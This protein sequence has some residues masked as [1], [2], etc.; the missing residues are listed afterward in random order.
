[1]NIE[2]GIRLSDSNYEFENST[3]N[4]TLSS[5]FESHSVISNY[6]DISKKSFLNKLF[7]FWSTKAMNISN[8]KNLKIKHLAKGQENQINSL[9]NIIRTEYNKR[10]NFNEDNYK[11]NYNFGKIGITPHEYSLKNKNKKNSSCPLFM[12]IL[13]SNIKEL[14]LITFFSILVVICKYLQIQ[15]LR[16]LIIIFRENYELEDNEEIKNNYQLKIRNKI[17]LYSAFFLINKIS[18]IFL[19]N[20]SNY[21]SQIL[22]IKA[23]NML[24]ALIYNKLL[25]ASSIYSGDLNEG[26]MI[27]Y[28]QVDIDHLGFVFF[29]AP[30]TFVV[31]IQFIINFYMLFNFF[32]YTFIFGLM[33]FLFLF[34]IAWIIQSLYISNQKILLKNKD[35]RMKIT[36]SVLHM[37]KIL[38][39]YV[40]EDEFFNRVEKEREQEIK[41][42]KKIQNITLLSR[43]VHSSIPLFLS[44]ASIGI[45]TLIKGKMVLENLLA[46]IEIFDT[47]SASLYRLPIFIT[48]L[49]NCLISMNRLEKFLNTKDFE[50]TSKEDEDLKDKN[51]DI[52]LNNCNFG[53]FNAELKK[54]KILLFDLDLEIKKGEL[55]AVLGET[56]SGKTCLT[57]AILNYLD[58]IPKSKNANEVYNIVNGAISYASQNPWILNGTVRDNIIFYNEL[59]IERYKKVLQICQLISDLSQLPGGD[60]A[61]ISSNGQ[62]ISGGQKARISLARAIYKDADIYLFDDPISSVDPINSERIFKSVLLDY[63][64]DKTRILIKHEMRNIELFSKI[65]YLKNGKIMF[66][67]NYQELIKSNIY[68]LLLDEY[69]NQNDFEKKNIKKDISLKLYRVHSERSLSIGH[70]KE[71]IMKGR[72]IK[73]EEMNEGSINKKLYIK[74]IIFMGGFTFFTLLVIISAIIQAFSLRG[75][76]WLM[77]W[78][79]GKNNDNLY[80]FLVYAEID[81]FSLFFLFLKE[82]LFSVAL[83]RMNKKLHNKMLNKII[84]A[85]INLFHDIVPIGQIINRLTSDLDKTRA[86]SKLLSLILRSFFMLITSIVVCF[87]YNSLS[88]ISALA[89]I[90]S[91]IFITNYY[92]S[93]GRNL[94]RLDGISRAPIVTCF[95]ETFSG[96]K[97]IKSFKREE[98]LKN[99]LFQFLNDYYYVISYKFGAANWY[100]LFLEISSYFYILFIILF[101]C[102]FYDSFSCQAIAL[103]IKYSVSFSDQM[104]NTFCFLSD[105][106]KSMVSFERCDLYT[107]IIQ[108]ESNEEK[109]RKINKDNSLIN[110]PSEGHIIIKNYSCK[111]RPDTEIVLSRVNAEIKAGEKIGIVGKSGSGKST[112]SLAFFRVI[113][114]FHGEIIIDNVN[115]SEISLTKLRKNMCIIPQD[116]TLF[117]ST[118]RDNVDPLKQYSDKEI[119]DILEELEFF[120][121]INIRKKIYINKYNKDYMKLCLN[122]KIK[123]NGGNIS[124]GNKQLLCFARAVLKNS[125]II[126]M[127]EATASLDQKT[128]GIILKAID[129]YFKNST[130][131]SIAHRIES[132]LNFDRIMVFDEGKLKE[133]DKPEELLKQKNSIFFKLYYEENE[134]TK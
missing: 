121:F 6:E 45:Y 91:G 4:D 69:T 43:F 89:M 40:W 21:R 5:S 84:H 113:E 64:K 36:S 52:K 124:L 122:Y 14:L 39:L 94:N 51:I 12:S 13:K 78:S 71:N 27:N 59:D 47:M 26:Q 46:S 96:A 22:A 55:V 119:F 79:T 115:I 42:M 35:K 44:V 2:L 108:E 11:T 131:F 85:P 10:V 103:I 9:F 130:L 20:H 86:I 16:L 24:S 65:I 68:H 90:L 104:L 61:E 87:H 49:L 82:F 41:S 95:S 128:Q 33:I 50:K 7:F 134:S 70:E 102:F 18:L 126:I 37:L 75:N 129:K 109:K 74:F 34:F 19:Q 92:I 53:I 73:D 116:P 112:L 132:V 30:M 98:N 8:N 1:M 93:A 77:Q 111:Y 28:L 101:S 97:I 3:K 88:I 63:L 118:V 32:G 106:E 100:S 38:K 110:W 123:E 114:A 67:G 62:N 25:N 117:E 83:L 76:I 58:F 56:G 17:Y 57:N 23:G 54:S 72:L 125:K 29:F 15:L 81:L 99:R 48:T 120:D 31:P 60:M 127:D 133:F 66:C 107:K 80:S 105:M